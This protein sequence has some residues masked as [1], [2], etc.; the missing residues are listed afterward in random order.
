MNKKIV[1]LIIIIILVIGVISFFT[2]S[3]IQ[4]NN[5]EYKIEEITKYNYFT[6]KNENKFGVI[7][8]KGEII[9]EAKYDEV[10]IPN[11]TKAVFVAY[12]ED[13]SKVVN[14]K[15]EEIYKGYDKIET[16]NLKN[17]SSDLIY[18]KQLL[19]YEKD[20]K[21]G[22]INLEG[23][24][25][26]KPIYDEIETLQ[27]K[28]GELLVKKD[29]KYGVINQKGYTLIKN[30]YDKITVDGYY[31][32][33]TSY[34]NDGYIVG[35]KTEEGYRYGYITAIGEKYLE[36][37]YNDVRRIVEIEDKE[38]QIYLLTAEN[39]RY[40]VFK[41]NQK[42]IENEYQSIIY[43][44][45]SSIFTVQKGK[46][47]GAINK[48]GKEVLKCEYSEIDIKGKNLYTKT[49][50]GKE[51]VYSNKGE[52]TNLNSDTIIIEIQEKPE[53][54]IYIKNS[55]GK[56]TY[57]I[58]KEGKA[59][60]EEYMYIQYLEKDLLIASKKDGKLGIIDMQ[61]TDKGEF[62]YTSIQKIF[63]TNIIQM[64]VGTKIELAN[65]EGKII[66]EME[67]AK[68]EQIDEYIK[69]S[70]DKEIKYFNLKGEEISNKEVYKNN[71]LYAIEK[72]GKWGFEDKN[73]N[74]KVECIYDEVIEFNQYGYAGI[75]KDGKWGVVDEEGKILEEP[76]YKIT[77]QAKPEFIG[78]Y[79]QIQYGFGQKYHTNNIIK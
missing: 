67:N 41:N 75:K 71:K 52:L 23:K 51:E 18:E 35:K 65:E 64:S 11:P 34:K 33:E 3:Q 58:C 54:E 55:E 14:E 72:D 21:F 42:L 22:L 73:Q 57:Q 10:K 38:D 9:I 16:L 8:N 63:D 36:C 78:K 2:Y 1:S 20:G 30:E 4:K 27:Y 59:I 53:Y 40:G 69:I 25:I 60:T 70:N 29:G 76:K 56:T 61:G 47:Y 79:Y 32:S 31:N 68:V 15:N 77:G 19:K 49:I 46:K 12:N 39:G 26:A 44:M 74:I 28:E 45:T 17:V 24:E 37:K 62:K 48:E 5:R 7:N 66:C 13:N 6:Y 50:E 43:D